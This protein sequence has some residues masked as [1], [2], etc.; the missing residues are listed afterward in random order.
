MY[1]TDEPP[2]IG[3]DAYRRDG[4]TW[5]AF[6]SLAGFGFLNA[7]LGP[8]LPYIRASEQISY[9]VGALH[10]AAF[11]IGGGI[12]GLWAARSSG[13]PGRAVII[14]AGLVGAAVAGL[15]VAFLNRPALTV[16]AALLMSFFGSS[17]LIR[18]WAA[19]SDAHDRHRAVVLTEGEVAVSLGGIFTPLMVSAL[20]ASVVGWRS[21]FLVGGAL[22]VAA[23]ALSSTMTVPAPRAALTVGQASIAASP[24]GRSGPT[25]VVVAAVVGL[26]FSLSLWL[27]S[28]LDENVGLPQ[29]LAVAVVAALYA[30]NLVGR[31]ATSRLARLMPTA[32][33]LTLALMVTLAGLPILLSAHGVAVAAVG[34]TVAG[35]GIGA[36]FPLASTLHIEAR[37]RPA[38][39][40]VGEVLV[41]A[42]LGQVTG[43]LMVAGIAQAAG[44]RVGLVTLPVLALLAAAG[45]AR[46]ISTAPPP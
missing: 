29:E 46:H 16:A 34:L 8:A 42:A 39:A 22:V 31:V 40:A 14:R 26:E 10:Q 43:P 11:A 7:V 20:A 32:R 2:P 33:L 24:S 21:S 17:A 1:A 4:F 45:L 41:C 37:A 30:A 35:A 27:A 12:A 13:R 6:G 36:L 5:A 19:L 25:L 38:D 3:S 18:L 15:G 44:L 23:V 9:V 28:Y